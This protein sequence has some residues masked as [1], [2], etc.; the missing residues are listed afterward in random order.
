V[1]VDPDGDK[2]VLQ[3]GVD[4]IGVRT[5]PAQPGAQ[6]RRMPVMQQPESLGPLS[7]DSTQQLGI[8]AQLV[9]RPL[10]YLA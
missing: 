2:R 9:D 6:P 7:R 4:H 8:T 1:G 3:R 5:A 10:R